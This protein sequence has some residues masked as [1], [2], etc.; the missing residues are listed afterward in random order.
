MDQQGILSCTKKLTQE[1]FNPISDYRPPYFCTDRNTQSI[2]IVD[3]GLGDN[4]EVGGGDLSSLT[5][6]DKELGTF[7]NAGPLGE[8][9]PALRQRCAPLYN[10][11]CFGGIVT[12]S[13]LRPLALLCFSTLR[14]PGVAI[15]ARKP[16]LLF[17]LML[18][19]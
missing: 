19:G 10:R 9:C 12:E 14:P 7:F 17:R 18:L 8:L 16:W 2:G 15:L 1:S 3:V 13:R 6:E 5:R 4:N 11:S